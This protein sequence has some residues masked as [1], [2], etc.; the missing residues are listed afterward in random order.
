MHSYDAETL[1]GGSLHHYPTLQA[2]DHLGAQSLEARHLGG[3][4][5]ALN[6]DVN[7][8]F[9]VHALDLHNGF[10]GR[11]LQHAVIS[12]STRMIGVYRTAQRLTPEAGSFLNSGGLTVDQD[13]A[14]AG[15][16]HNSALRFLE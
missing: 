2:L 16:V 8:T 1:A 7:A 10:V 4:V 9:M 5:I 11:S 14:E 6:V 13:G 3:N 12:A 15:S